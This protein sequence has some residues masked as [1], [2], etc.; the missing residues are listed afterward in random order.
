MLKV[1]QLTKPPVVKAIN[2][3]LECEILQ[4]ITGKKKDRVYRYMF[5]T[6]AKFGNCGI[7]ALMMK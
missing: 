2:I 7:M 4:E 1:L 3:L 5:E 6:V